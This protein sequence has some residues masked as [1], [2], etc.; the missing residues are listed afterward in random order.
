MQRLPPTPTHVGQTF[1]M[2]KWMDHEFK[3]Q[4]GTGLV[5]RFLTHTFV[6]SEGEEWEVTMASRTP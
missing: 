2:E 5:Y 3:N 4:Q 6:K 1:V